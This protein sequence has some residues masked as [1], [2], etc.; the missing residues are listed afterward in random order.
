MVPIVGV[1]KSREQAEIAAKAL[2]SAGVPRDKINMLAPGASSK[3]I[4]TIPVTDTEQTGMGK[5]MGGVVGG[6]LGAAAG[7]ELGAIAATILIPGF[8][9]IIGIGAVAV[10]LLGGGGAIGGFFLGGALDEAMTEG[11]PVDEMYVYEDALRRGRAVLFA[12]AHDDAQAATVRRVLTSSGA[13]TVDAA[14]ES[15][16]L[17]LRTDEEAMYLSDGLDFKAD[18]SN[19]RDGFETAQQVRFRDRS[20]DQA[21]DDLLKKHPAAGAAEAFRRGYARGQSYRRDLIARHSQD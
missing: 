5:A 8:G 4:E 19:F 15:W 10:A 12:F 3:Q 13:E 21:K 2:R 9:A 11:L 20:Y 16:W 1:F 6:A 17:G 18:E 14:L 7:A